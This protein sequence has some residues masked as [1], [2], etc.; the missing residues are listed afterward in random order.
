MEKRKEVRFNQLEIGS[1][2]VDHLVSWVGLSSS[3]V[4]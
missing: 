3:I 4:I 1:D 2:S